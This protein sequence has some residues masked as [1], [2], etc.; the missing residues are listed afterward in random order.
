MAMPDQPLEQLAPHV[1]DVYEAVAL[2]TNVVMLLCILLR[3][4]DVDAVSDALDAEG[5][6]THGGSQPPRTQPTLIICSRPVSRSS[7]VNP[8]RSSPSTRA[9]VTADTFKDPWSADQAS[10]CGIRAH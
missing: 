5:R 7:L 10:R 4:R 6:K 8:S 3:V 2:P 9:L 1:E